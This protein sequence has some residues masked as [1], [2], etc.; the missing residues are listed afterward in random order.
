MT[1]NAIPGGVI[2]SPIIPLTYM[3]PIILAGG[4]VGWRGLMLVAGSSIVLMIG[5]ARLETLPTPLS[6]YTLPQNPDPIPILITVTM[7]IGVSCILLGLVGWTLRRAMEDAVARQ[8]ELELLRDSLE[9][10]VAERTASLETALREGERREATL[11]ATLVELQDTRATVRELSAPVIPVLPGV[12]VAPLVGAMDAQ[13]ITDFA[14]HL[15]HEV[16]RQRAT[17][18]VL[19][20]TGMPIVDTQVAQTLLHAATSVRLLGGTT[21]LVGVRPEVAQTMV[22]LGTDLT[23]LPTYPDLREAV[24]TLIDRAEMR[25]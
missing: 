19:D 23:R 20:I 22:M 16:E 14:E 6:G 9:Q 2:R 5:I 3:L 13:R 24:A 7:I 17:H 1:V 4:I 10:T 15:L 18:V 8:R 11:S 25:R 12:L 21:M